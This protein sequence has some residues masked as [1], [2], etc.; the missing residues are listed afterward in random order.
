MSSHETLGLLLVR[1]GVIARPQLYDALRLQRQ[2]GRL[3]GTC[4]MTLGYIT[5]EVLLEILARQLTIPALPLGLL[6]GAAPEAISRVP[7]DVAARLRAVPYSWDGEM[8][9]VAVADGRALNHLHEVAFH[10]QSAVGAYVALESEIDAA[11][12]AFYPQAQ[13]A[14]TSGS[15]AN[16]ELSGR[17]RPARAG[18][19]NEVSSR[20]FAAALGFETRADP[21]L[22]S[23]KKPVKASSAQP[24]S[25]VFK[26]APPRAPLKGPPPP[27]PAPPPITTAPPPPA[28][29]PTPD[30]EAIERMGFYDAVEFIYESSSIEELGRTVGRAL[31][32]YFTRVLVL[33]IQG[34]EV[35]PVGFAGVE[36]PGNA[37]TLD[38]LPAVA[39]AMT[40]RNIAYGPAGNDMRAAEIAGAFGIQPGATSLIAPVG[41]A[42]GVCLLAFAD[43]GSTTDLYED[44]H[45]VELLFKEAETALGMMLDAGSDT[46]SPAG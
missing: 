14:G 30:A 5:P 45:D 4:L 26:G 17:P 8:L 41:A 6:A 7:G 37:K 13:A 10:S 24:E 18:P 12:K 16:P 43:N 31:L 40:Q 35:A 44:L 9:G 23:K 2:N 32:N 19:A 20:D 22:L 1:D 15:E 33:R 36:P 34:T 39:G 29:T 28:P 21:V 46:A 11:L 25:P 42:N 38:A 3:L 27:A